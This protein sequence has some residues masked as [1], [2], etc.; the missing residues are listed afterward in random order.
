MPDGPDN[1][2]GKAREAP[3][4]SGAVTGVSAAA[5]HGLRVRAVDL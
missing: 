1:G 5:H 3:T 4:A 2:A